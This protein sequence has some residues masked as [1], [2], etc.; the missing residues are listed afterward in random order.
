MLILTI[1][2]STAGESYELF[3][4]L[5]LPF[6]FEL[7]IFRLLRGEKFNSSIPGRIGYGSPGNGRI[8]R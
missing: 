8:G 4:P 3:L 7:L 1:G 6:P 2:I 5:P